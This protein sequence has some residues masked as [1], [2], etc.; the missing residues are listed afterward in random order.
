LERLCVELANDLFGHRSL[1]ELNERKP[2]WPAGFP[3]DGHD[4]V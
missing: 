3:V 2:A 1:G 4:D